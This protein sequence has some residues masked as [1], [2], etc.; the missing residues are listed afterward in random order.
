MR[1]IGQLAEHA[2][3]YVLIYGDG[4][5]Q[6]AE[7]RRRHQV[8]SFLFRRAEHCAQAVAAR[9]PRALALSAADQPRPIS[10]A[11]LYRPI[12]W[13]KRQQQALLRKGHG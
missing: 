5:E 3:D 2:A 12:E 10:N 1:G 9:K 7:I 4:F 13:G 11:A 6:R 8:G